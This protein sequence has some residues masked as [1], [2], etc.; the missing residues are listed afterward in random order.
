MSFCYHLEKEGQ[1]NRGAT[2]QKVLIPPYFHKTIWH[3]TSISLLLLALSPFL[4]PECCNCLPK[5]H[6]PL[7]QTLMGISMKY[8]SKRH[9]KLKTKFE[10]AEN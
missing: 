1:E 7:K 9:L 3:I 5:I 4:P 2:F 6:H 10:V 8:L